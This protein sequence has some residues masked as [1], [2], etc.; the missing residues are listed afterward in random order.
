MVAIKMGQIWRPNCS[1]DYSLEILS[2]S[3]AEVE[4]RQ[5]ETGE[6]YMHELDGSDGFV[7]FLETN[8]YHL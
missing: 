4:V 2:I 5:I 1:D 3:D 6:I 7:D 8:L